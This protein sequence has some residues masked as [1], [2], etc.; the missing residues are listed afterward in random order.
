MSTVSPFVAGVAAASVT[1]S[2]IDIPGAISSEVISTLY[3]A[4]LGVNRELV[5]GNPT[6]LAIVI[7]PTDVWP[8]D[9][10]DVFF[11]GNTSPVLSFSVPKDHD[12][13]SSFDRFIDAK[14]VPEGFS[15]LFYRL[16]GAESAHLK[17]LAW[18]RLPGGNDP[19]PE[20]PGHH[21]LLAPQ[22]YTTEIDGT[23]DIIATVL[24]WPGM[25]VGQ[26]L[27][28]Q[29]G[30]YS[31]PRTVE[32]SEVG[33]G[34]VFTLKQDMIAKLG[35]CTVL[36]FYKLWDEVGNP[37]SDHSLACRLTL[38]RPMTIMG[39]VNAWRA[40]R[41]IGLNQDN[42]IDLS[43]SRRDDIKVEIDVAANKLTV[44]Q[45][46]QLNWWAEPAVDTPQ[47]S[48]WMQTVGTA[49]TLVFSIPPAEVQSL[50]GGWCSVTWGLVQGSDEPLLS[51][52][53]ECFFID[54]S[55]VEI[56]AADNSILSIDP[57]FAPESTMPVEGSSVMCGIPISIYDDKP[58]GLNITL[59]PYP[60]KEA[61]DVIFL[62][63]NGEDAPV[64]SHNVEE[65]TE[66]KLVDFY[67][68]H[69]R[70]LDGINTLECRVRRN[71]GNEENSRQPLTMLY[72]AVRPG[73]KDR[74]GSIEG[75]S[76]LTLGFPIAE[77]NGVDV[78][79]EGLDGNLRQLTVHCTYPFCRA[80]DHIDIDFGG[81]VVHFS[82]LPSQAPQI[83]SNL[84]TRVTVVISATELDRIPSRRA[85]PVRF[86][87]TDRVG[88]ITDPSSPWSAAT[89]IDV[90]R[91]NE[92]L[93]E[94][95][96]R[97][98]PADNNDAAE[99]IDL[100][101]L[102][103][104]PLL[105]IVR[106]NH[107]SYRA[108][109]EVKAIFRSPPSPD[110]SVPMGIV[111]VE[112]GQPKPL[113]LQVPNNLL[114][115][116]RAVSA[117]Y[118]TD[119]KTVKQQNYSR[120]A[121]ADV[122]GVPLPDLK[123]PWVIDA[124]GGVLYPL[125]NQ[126]GATAWVE[127]LEFLPGD[128]VRLV[129]E[130][131]SGAGSPVFQPIALDATGK[132][133][134]PLNPAFIVANMGRTVNIHYVLIRSSEQKTSPILP[135][136]VRPIDNLDN[137]LPTPLIDRYPG[138]TLD[139]FT[140]PTDNSIRTR[141]ARWSFIEQQPQW[142][143]LDYIGV[144]D[145]G[146]VYRESTYTQT[147]MPAGGVA[148]GLA[149]FT[150][151]LNLRKLR[152]KSQLTIEFRI[153][154]AQGTTKDR[155]LLFPIKTYTI[156][157]QSKD[158]PPP[159][160]TEATGTG[161]TVTLQ[162]E[163]AINGGTVVVSYTS[164][165]TQD[166]ITLTVRGRAGL[167]SPVIASKDGESDASVL[168]TIP[169]TAIAA[170]FNRSFVVFYTVTRNGVVLP[171]SGS[172]TVN[173]GMPNL[174]TPYIKDPVGDVI[175]VSTLAG[176][177]RTSVV[178]WPFQRSGQF[179]HLNYQGT[180]A[181][182]QATSLVVWRG[183]AHNS[184]DGMY[185]AA[186][187]AWL[188]TLKNDST[189]TINFAVSFTGVNTTADAT[190]FPVRTYTVKSVPTNLQLPNLVE[191]NGTG[192]AQTLA[193]LNA[194]NGATVRIVVTGLLTTDSIKLTLTGTPGAG[195][196]NL[197]AVPGELDG[198][199]DI[200]IPA[201][202]IAAN[203]GNGVNATF[204]L[205][206]V[207]TRGTEAYPSGV[208]TVTVTPLPASSLIP[209]VF[210]V[211]GV[212]ALDVLDL[213]QFTGNGLLHG[214]EWSFM[215]TGQ[216]VFLNLEGKNAN[217]QRHY[218][219]IWNGGGSVVNDKWV[220][221]KK[222]PA[223][224]NAA[225][226]GG[227]GHDT[228]LRIVF[229]ASL[230]K[231]NKLNTAIAFPERVYT[232]KTVSVV[233]TITSVKAGTTEV[234]DNGT[235]DQPS[236]VISGTASAGH[237]L[238]IYDGETLLGPVTVTAARIWTLPARTF[239]LA[240]HVITARTT[241]G[242]RSLERIFTVQ[243]VE[244]APTI[245]SVLAGSVVIPPGGDT[246]QT[247]ITVTGTVTSGRPVDIYNNNTRLGAGT[248]TGSNWTIGPLTF[249]VGTHVLTARTLDGTKR[250]AERRFTVKVETQT[251]TIA[252]VNSGGG[253]VANRGQTYYQSLGITGGGSPGHQI[254]IYD[255]A[256]LLG[257][258]PTTNT[259]SWTLPARNFS[260]G[261]HSITA[262]TTDGSNK[263]SLAYTFT[264][265]QGLST[266]ITNFHYRQFN[267]WATGNAIQHRDLTFHFNHGQYVLNNYTYTNWS[268]GVLL[269]KTFYNLQPNATYYF[270]IRIARFYPQYAPPYIRL[271]TDQSAGQAW[272]IHTAAMSNLTISFSSTTPQLTLYID[273]LE[274]SGVG[275][276][277]DMAWIQ[278]SKA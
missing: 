142:V 63:L 11:S 164:M 166:R 270:T 92:R 115:S 251:P 44:G 70:L 48:T 123:A 172:L 117:F 212:E 32:Q 1:D 148:G 208:V 177:E 190:P 15:E 66:A 7:P 182:G 81:Y 62:I 154:F 146:S 184:A 189:F 262:R 173:V 110:Y 199:V 23:Q 51:P 267:G 128:Q 12:G 153:S 140:L 26:S 82:V 196:P 228:P 134:F 87:V 176:T 161:T 179:I 181:N 106:T 235:T 65:G 217:G 17:M 68:P 27:H 243:A 220:R 137:K 55:L 201:R 102:A 103:G 56:N 76:E 276:D 144:N 200:S 75:H 67:L 133:Q 149:P 86:M 150:P 256:T 222:W 174:P 241:D 205:S 64:A 244:Q 84:P 52:T 8:D 88:N 209:P 261:G 204:T 155:A 83:P 252:A 120:T 96:F 19:K 79:K 216:Q 85:V 111:E 171:A 192:A 126:Q 16:N 275:N 272:Y 141:V 151:V 47:M 188:R 125:N 250:S 29:F 93:P 143:W 247:R 206:Y 89:I 90:D 129:V 58:G 191:A 40:P 158:L 170:N 122:I 10:I 59:D 38:S 198:S 61:R 130:G 225:Y 28:L 197:P 101:K 230:N 116:G 195:T 277:W 53:A 218:T 233:P 104:R 169:P 224:V 236:L 9:K 132:A 94:P 271:R 112:F 211:N 255:G 248:V 145:D 253:V 168:F 269:Y 73:I 162:P 257:S 60:G 264:V 95:I 215:E 240:R 98:D 3:G 152:D 163:R 185:Y 33:H 178:Q 175:N 57:P 159:T 118:E 49:P 45:T 31:L 36:L 18:K 226:L 97:E 207:V 54:S 34:V 127:M 43:E 180:L 77:N 100:Q 266:D 14:W 99:I 221:D 157:A 265:Q 238:N 37:A 183:A 119:F 214:K 223:S 160:L 273:S 80:Y 30:N 263:T 72:H 131:A 108:G 147:P 13:N 35:S 136:T 213:N 46:V 203:I 187:Y 274:V 219:N 246:I 22:V 21:L 258:V 138:E 165:T 25:R 194:V 50:A 193:P 6:G 239:S 237:T 69:R 249:A 42:A 5:L 41:I 268:N 260:F 39:E 4:D 167:G 234:P 278:V 229:W 113:I 254:A 259:G 121:W 186:P 242:K 231:A 74:D 71:S 109:D 135:L 78:V 124:P 107:P 156:D 20:L 202:V 91:K 245:T 24:P 139:P 227:L 2:L 114:I 210:V 232:V 105:L